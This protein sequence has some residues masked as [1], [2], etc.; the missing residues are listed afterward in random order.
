VTLGNGS[1]TGL[2]PAAIQWSPNLGAGSFMQVYASAG[3]NAGDTWTIDVTSP[4]WSST[5]LATVGADQFNVQA[6][7]GALVIDGW[8][9]PTTVMVGSQAPVA[10]GTLA[11]I[12]GAIS[13]DPS[14][15]GDTWLIV[16]DSG[17]I[18]P[19]TAEVGTNS[20]TG[21]SPAPIV[22]QNNYDDGY[23]DYTPGVY[24]LWVYGGSGGTTS[25]V[26]NT[27]PCFD[28]GTETFLRTGS[29]NDTVNVQATSG[30]LAVYN[31]GGT[32]TVTVGSQA[33]SLGGTLA[34]INGSVDVSGSGA[35]LLNV[36]DSGD[37]TGRTATLA[38]GSLTGLAPAPIDWTPTSRF[39]GGVPRRKSARTG[40]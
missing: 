37:T 8:G 18:T 20:L 24:S 35:T 32:D 7:A 34:N 23:G 14:Q 17:D 38:N 1:L 28:W 15:A 22:W 27:P 5:N 12:K 19:R 39:T 13:I 2:A 29:G 26:T 33:P 31:T 40:Q 36:D 10:G 21:L 4:S 9:Y 30:P 25:D 11:N 3:V 6:T 16:D